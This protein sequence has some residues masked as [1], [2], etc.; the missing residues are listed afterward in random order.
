MMTR[1][2]PWCV[3]ERGGV[4]PVD[5]FARLLPLMTDTEVP[6]NVT[7][8][9]TRSL[10]FECC[11]DNDGRICTTF[12]A[13]SGDVSCST[14]PRGVNSGAPGL[15]TIAGVFSPDSGE[16]A[17][18][19]DCERRERTLELNRPARFVQDVLGE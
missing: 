18:E 2:M 11:L 5:E 10:S 17:C 12:L 13:A 14:P 19:A 16:P 15:L 3:V 6:P 7:M 8:E 9:G 4:G 1:F